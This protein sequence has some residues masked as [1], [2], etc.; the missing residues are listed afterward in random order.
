MK[1]RDP[2]I[3]TEPGTDPFENCKLERRPYAEILTQIVGSYAD[4]FVLALNNEWGAGKTTFIKMWRQHLNNKG[5]KTLYF[6]AWENDFEKDVLVA[7][8]SELEELKESKNKAAY[9][10]LL[11]KAA[12]LTKKV[13]P[14]IV[15]AGLKR[16]GIDGEAALDILQGTAEV[17]F[18]ALEE[19]IKSYTQRKKS[20]AEFRISLEEFVETADPKNPIIFFIDELD[21]C[22]PT[23]AV[24][25]LE[26]V[27]HLFS[28]PGIVFVLSIDK[29]QLGHAV[30]GVYGSEQI[31]SEE[32]L[33]RFIDLEYSLPKPDTSAICT[34]LYEHFSFS[35]FVEHEQRKGIQEFNNDKDRFIKFSTLLLSSV[36]TNFRQAEK[37]FA[38]ARVGI[39][40]FEVN[41]YLF[42]RLYLLL[43]YLKIYEPFLYR[44][45]EDRK[46]E[47]QEL[48]NEVEDLY[49][50]ETG[51]ERSVDSF[52]FTIVEMAIGY[53]NYYHKDDYPR[54]GLFVEGAEPPVLYF[55]S[56]YDP[57]G[58]KRLLLD[59]YER[60]RY[61]LPP[62]SFKVDF[63]LRKINLT[64]PIINLNTSP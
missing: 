52:V 57:S 14:G 7:L 2:I 18:E 63:L 56:K 59:A 37:L 3:P 16:A 31:N 60:L 32:Y 11:T 13:A 61:A 9:K 54:K 62:H 40:T 28:V 51:E 1:H 50:L 29:E 58:N 48:I 43:V 8:I 44:R 24:E 22:R 35:Q 6:N 17:G 26:E 19:E 4:G 33:R 27:K 38:L 45:I 41:N 21:R 5:V 15:K 39:R 47:V 42:P 30:R 20:L 55:S 23:Y 46:I 10:N 36:N 49:S 53:H 64:E 34:Y 25:V 12:S